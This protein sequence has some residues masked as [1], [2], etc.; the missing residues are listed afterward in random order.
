MCGIREWGQATPTLYRKTVAIM[1]EIG[2][3]DVEVLK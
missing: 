2:M 1:S 3:S